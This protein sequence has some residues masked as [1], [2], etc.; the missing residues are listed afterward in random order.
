[1]ITVCDTEE[2]GVVEVGRVWVVL[3]DQVVEHVV[4]SQLQLVLLEEGQDL[5]NAQAILYVCLGST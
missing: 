5:L 3:E 2:G 4:D 1:M